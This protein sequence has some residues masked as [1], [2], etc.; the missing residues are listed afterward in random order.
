ML[1]GA[2]TH[3]YHYD[4]IGSVTGITS[5]T[6]PTEW[7]YPSEPFGAAWLTTKVDPNAP[8]NPLRFPGQYED[9]PSKLVSLRARQY[10]TTTGRFLGTA[11]PNPQDPATRTKALTTTP[12]KTRSTH[13]TSTE[14]A[15]SSRRT[16]TRRA[17][18]WM[19][20]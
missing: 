4:R 16:T 10:D 7:T 6:G 9:P 14:T 20:R 2:N 18:A 5:G 12:P 11:I 8:V 17:E 13:T 19:A 3:Y 15:W 1:E